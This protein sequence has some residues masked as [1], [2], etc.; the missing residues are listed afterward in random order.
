MIRN[1]LYI[2]LY[3]AFYISVTF[4]IVS[5]GIAFRC[6]SI[7]ILYLK[8]VESA[9]PP[10]N[11][12]LLKN[13]IKSFFFLISSKNMNLFIKKHIHKQIGMCCIIENIK[14]HHNINSP[15]GLQTFGQFISRKR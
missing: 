14:K 11:H 9:F 2:L 10:E 6:D 3:I 12:C 1:L 4:I 13:A 15:L 5:N 8:L 7:S